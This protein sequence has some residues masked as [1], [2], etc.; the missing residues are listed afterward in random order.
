[1]A[2][3]KGQSGNPGGRPKGRQNNATQEIRALAQSLF[4]KNYWERTKD[5]SDKAAH[6]RRFVANRADSDTFAKDLRTVVQELAYIFSSK[7]YSEA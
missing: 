4:D 2:F 7:A 5:L 3:A 1:M 6:S